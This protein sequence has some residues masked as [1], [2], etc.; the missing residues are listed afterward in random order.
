[1]NQFL[2]TFY[3]FTRK[4]TLLHDSTQL[5]RYN[6]RSAL[7]LLV[8]KRPIVFFSGL[9]SVDRLKPRSRRTDYCAGYSTWYANK[10]KT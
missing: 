8:S 9:K 6:F 2:E 5:A 10:I 7:S 1:M 3:Q 4:P